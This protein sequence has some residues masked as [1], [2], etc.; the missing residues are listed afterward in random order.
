MPDGICSVSLCQHTG[1]MTE[2]GKLQRPERALVNP[3]PLEA[4]PPARVRRGTWWTPGLLSQCSGSSLL[5]WDFG[6]RILHIR[7]AW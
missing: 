6:E 3:H 5:D 1:V 2:A 4:P 7:A